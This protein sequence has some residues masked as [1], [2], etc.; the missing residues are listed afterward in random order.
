[1]DSALAKG[2]KESLTVSE[3]WRFLIMELTMEELQQQAITVSP[4]LEDITTVL[5]GRP[6]SNWD[7]IHLSA[8][9][10][11]MLYSMRMCWQALRYV[12]GVA[13]AGACV[14]RALDD[15]KSG[16]SLL[17]TT[18][19]SLPGIADFFEPVFDISGTVYAA[20]WKGQ[21]EVYGATYSRHYAQHKEESPEVELA[22]PASLGDDIPMDDGSSEDDEGGSL[23]GNPF[24][25]LAST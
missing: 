10:Q 7:V 16:F 11:T 8:R 6:T 1:M 25:A 23:A 9:Y 22:S 3:R 5:M 19:H 4:T 20:E 15:S 17:L 21:G 12:K 24:A 13:D 14:H 18:L 2:K